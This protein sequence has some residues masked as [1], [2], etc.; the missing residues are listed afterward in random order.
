MQQEKNIKTTLIKEYLRLRQKAGELEQFKQ[1]NKKAYEA[2]TRF[3]L[4]LSGIS[5]LAYICDA[6]GN[7]IYVNE[8]FERLTGQNVEDFIGKPFARLIDE[9]CLKKADDARLRALNGE[10][11]QCELF[12]KDTGTLCEFRNTPVRDE[13]GWV[14]GFMGIARETTAR[15]QIED[16][17]DL[18]RAHLEGIL[19]ERTA[20]LISVNEEL[21]KQAAARERL[22]KELGDHENMYRALLGSVNDAFFLADAETGIIIYANS[23]A[24]ELIGVPAN[25][26]IGMHQ[27]E[28]HPK[29]DAGRYIKLFKEAGSRSKLSLKDVFVFN[30]EGRKVPVEIFASVIEV[31]GRKLVQGVFKD[32]SRN[33]FAD[34]ELKR[35]HTAAEHSPA[36]VSITD[37][38]GLIDYVNPAFRKMAGYNAF[39]SIGLSIKS[40][41]TGVDIHENDSMWLTVFEGNAWKGRVRCVNKTGAVAFFT[42]LITPV[43]NHKDTI[44]SILFMQRGVEGIGEGWP[45]LDT[46]EFI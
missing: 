17:L 32:I 16:E 15:R 13:R 26:I 31:N 33:R 6:D 1:E 45:G 34:L 3:S 8:A 11:T 44:T 40:I 5:D 12:F 36:W 22:E 21:L 29:N 39:E 42:G 30:R 18:Y 25:E 14:T 9:R 27:K 7:I 24:E 4:L 10:A 35:F 28:L 19:N 20:E 41:I 43:K 46:E 23:K 2:L 38:R 37:I